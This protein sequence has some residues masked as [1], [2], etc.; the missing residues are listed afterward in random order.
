MRQFGTCT[1][2]SGP[3]RCPC[4]CPGTRVSAETSNSSKFRVETG[5]Q[6]GDLFIPLQV[7]LFLKTIDC[8][9]ILTVYKLYLRERY[10]DTICTRNFKVY[11]ITSKHQFSAKLNEISLITF[12]R[13]YTQSLNVRI[14]SVNN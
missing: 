2:I 14:V 11:Q 3:E 1:N 4:N 10:N 9:N 5:K 12:V 8:I 7:Y 6:L 13:D